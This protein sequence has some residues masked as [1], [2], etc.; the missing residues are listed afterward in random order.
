MECKLDPAYQGPACITKTDGRIEDDSEGIAAEMAR[1]LIDA[2]RDYG[3]ERI[4]ALAYE[5]EVDF[6]EELGFRKTPG[7]VP[8]EWCADQPVSAGQVFS[9]GAAR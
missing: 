8:M 7:L 1:R 9:A 3:V 6:C 4:D 5:T 2:L